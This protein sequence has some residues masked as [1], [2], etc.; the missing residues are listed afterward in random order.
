MTYNASKLTIKS[1]AAKWLTDVAYYEDKTKRADPQENV[2]D[3]NHENSQS[4]GWDYGYILERIQ[5][6]F[7]GCNTSIGCLR[8]Y[9]NCIR[10]GS[11]G[12]EGHT[13]PSRRMRKRIGKNEIADTDLGGF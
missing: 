9:A 11:H 1:I 3:A 7:K 8:W 5:E 13:L 6:E 2:V 12:M 10:E 4:V